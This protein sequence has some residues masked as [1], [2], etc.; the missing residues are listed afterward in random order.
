MPV[1][2]SDVTM[3]KTF[4]MF[5]EIR[6]EEKKKETFSFSSDSCDAINS[7]KESFGAF[8]EDCRFS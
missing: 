7:L 6:G 2:D 5:P 3:H 4:P 1:T 8:L